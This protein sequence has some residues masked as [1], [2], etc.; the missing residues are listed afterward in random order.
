MLVAR[1]RCE[2]L[3]LV[4]ADPWVGKYAVDVLPVT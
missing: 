4:G 2:R 3:T 1:A